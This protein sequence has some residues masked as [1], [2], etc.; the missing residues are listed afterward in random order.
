MKDTPDEIASVMNL[1]LPDTPEDQFPT[2][3]KFIA[4]Y[5]KKKGLNL[6]T[7]RKDMIADL[8]SKFKGR[9]SFLKSMKSVVKKEFIGSKNIGDLKHFIVE[10]I[11]MSEYQTECYNN[12]IS[13]DKRA[14]SGVYTN[15]RQA[16]VFVFPDKSY[17]S[18]GFTQNVV[19]KE[20]TNIYK[21]VK[22]GNDDKSKP[23]YSFSLKPHVI[24]SIKGKNNKETLE[25]LYKFSS[26]YAYIIEKILEN[27]KKSC[28][29]YSELVTGSGSIVFAEILKLFGFSSSKGED[30][31]KPGLRYGLLTSETTSA[32][33]ISNIINCFNQP[34]N[35]NGEIIRVLIGSRLVSEGVSFYN[36]QQEF[37][38]TPWFNYSETEQAIARGY[39]LNSHSD[40]IKDGD[41]PKVYIYQMVAIPSNKKLMSIDLHMYETSE[42][43][44]ITIR[45]IMRILME[46][47]FDC[48]LNYNR[49]KNDGKNGE[50]DCDYQNCEHVCD[51]IDMEYIKNGLSNEEI[52]NST[53]QLYYSDPKV[54]IIRKKLDKIFK[55]YNEL[56]VDS[57]LKYFDGEY[58]E[59]EIRNALSTIINKSNENLY[60]KDYVNIY[61]NSAVKK[62]MFGIEKL[63]Q[64]NFRISFENI[65][66][67][68][69]EYTVFEIVTALKNIIDES[70]VIKNK[71]GFSSYLREHNNT[72]FLV[73]SLSINHNPFS[74][75]YSREPNIVNNQI[76]S[77]ILHEIQIEL[78]PKYIEMICKT[79]K[80]TDFAKLIKSIPEEIQEIFIEAAVLAEKQ[81]V[82]TN[83]TTRK[84]ILD[85]FSNY[86][87]QFD[88]VWLSSRLKDKEVLRCLEKDKWEDCNDEYRNKLEQRKLQQKDGLEKNPWGYYGKYNPETKTFS[89][90][91]VVAQLLKH[92]KSQKDKEKIDYRN[93]FSGKNCTSWSVK[94]L[95]KVGINVLKLD[96]PESFK[97]SEN[98]SELRKLVRKDKYLSS[99]YT[100]Q[101]IKQL[102]NDQL[103]RSLFY[104]SKPAKIKH[105]CT[106]IEKWMAKTK[107]QGFDMLIPDSEVGTQ[108]G[109]K[110][111]LTKEKS[112]N[113]RIESIIPEKNVQKFKYYLKD[114]QKL[115][116]DCFKIQKYSPELDNKK[117]VMAF[118]GKKL[119]GF[120]TID[121]SNIIWNVCV[122]T[123]YRRDGIARQALQKAVEYSCPIKNPRL[124]VDNKGKTYNKLIKLYTGYGFKIV[125]NDGKITTMEFECK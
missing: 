32:K 123:N 71:Y 96:Y 8:K 115:M 55:K 98:D 38:V 97:S 67:Q 7:V 83:Q 92:K 41:E 122:A 108:G 60:Y 12:A 35:K 5:L 76:F 46:S 116:L 86:I 80:E 91:N 84:L 78:L 34:A 112:R 53:Y 101:E 29:V 125:K 1:I 27:P 51:G 18:N 26:K 58:T 110:K 4:K 75:Y 6:Y 82:V 62:I 121:S 16:S 23:I 95:L 70:I 61:S 10:P 54:P 22:S 50:R 69:P 15:A 65:T 99:I 11:K 19:K 94:D 40:L 105:L 39:R 103:R 59:S 3:D 13:L 68:F 63:F 85:Y 89:I 17:G 74:E 33:Q 100:E 48:A 93:E 124:Y 120:L 88:N 24:N 73:D 37:I 64:T 28:F 113:Y 43:K 25:N 57:I 109:H 2:G 119:V 47:A 14:I 111:K 102:N 21:T 81:K 107:W 49:N 52:D 118:L 56:D 90:V 87:H 45:G 106:E 77:E 31:Q 20:V 114:I 79:K 9:V 66:K 44:D 72:Y 36:I 104:V 30:G 117:W 42:D